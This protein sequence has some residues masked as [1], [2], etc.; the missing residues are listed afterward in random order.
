M[1]SDPLSFRQALEADVPFLLAL[2]ERTMAGHQLASGVEPSEAERERRVRARFD[3]A[4]IILLAGEPVGLLKVIKDGS[5]WELMQIQ[6][7]PERQRAGLGARIVQ[8]VISDARRAGASLTLRVLRANPAR[9]LYERL[10]FVVVSE[11]PH[12]CEMRLRDL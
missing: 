3:C 8:S 6:L 11:G 2:R 9:Q 7:V 5:Q 10:G 4:Q 12:S 1:Q